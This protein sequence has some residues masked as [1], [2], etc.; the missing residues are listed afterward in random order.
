VTE[1]QWDGCGKSATYHIFNSS[2]RDSAL[3]CGFHRQVALIN[4]DEYDLIF[5]PNT[6]GKSPR[7]PGDLGN[8]NDNSKRVGEKPGWE[9]TAAQKASEGA[10]PIDEFDMKRM[11]R[12]DDIPSP[13]SQK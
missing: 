1:C 3:L 7:R 12:I 2:G 9:Q 10:V 4:L 5:S 11:T 8:V 6:H 13:R